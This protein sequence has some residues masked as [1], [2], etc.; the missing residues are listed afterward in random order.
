MIPEDPWARYLR[1]LEERPEAFAPD[2]GLPIITD[3][4][5]AAAFTARTGRPLGVLYESPYR[6]LV[7]DL[8]RGP[9]GPFAY[10]RI[11]PASTGA[12]VVL[13]PLWEGRFVLLRQ[14]RHALRAGQLAFPRGYGEDG[15]SPEE[16]ARKEL[17]EE[18][19]SEAAALESLGR[20][21]PDSGMTGT[22]AHVFLCRITRPRPPL[23]Y[24]EIQGMV[25]LSPGELGERIAAGEIDDG[26]T[27]AAYGLWTAKGSRS[28]LA[29]KLAAA[30]EEIANG[31]PGKD[32]SEVARRLRGQVRGKTE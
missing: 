13:M 26:F 21:T 29:G 7:V 8:V 4:R 10:E 11:L 32:F 17:A 30:E 6:L 23:G 12:A 15:L 1:L 27:L 22:R 28:D 19:R 31:A 18:L 5:E 9:C 25:C 16:N 14:F 3:T 24:E 2:P 20:V